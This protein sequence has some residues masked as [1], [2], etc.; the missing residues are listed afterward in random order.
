MSFILFGCSIEKK[1]SLDYL[2]K[3]DYSLMTDKFKNSGKVSLEI[4][5]ILVMSI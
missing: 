1:Q 3:L 5:N 2:E 4:S